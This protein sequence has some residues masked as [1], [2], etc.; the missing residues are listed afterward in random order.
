MFLKTDRR[1]SAQKATHWTVGGKQGHAPVAVIVSVWLLRSLLFTYVNIKGCKYVVCIQCNLVSQRT[2]A[3]EA[4][5][6]CPT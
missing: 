3:G 6:G 2:F 5:I 1:V 4:V